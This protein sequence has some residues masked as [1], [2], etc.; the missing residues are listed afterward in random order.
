MCTTPMMNPCLGNLGNGGECMHLPQDGAKRR[1]KLGNNMA[2]VL[3][4]ARLSLIRLWSEPE[5]YKNE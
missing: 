5:L 3:K 4:L 1:T 2:P